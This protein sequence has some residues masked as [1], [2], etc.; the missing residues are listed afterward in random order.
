MI[1]LWTIH[2]IYIKYMRLCWISSIIFVCMAV[3][4]VMG[5]YASSIGSMFIVIMFPIVTGAEFKKGEHC[6]MTLYMVCFMCA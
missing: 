4:L 6:H 1:S 2:I 5:P 3:H